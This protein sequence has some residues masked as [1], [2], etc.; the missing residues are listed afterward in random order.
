MSAF[1]VLN[2]RKLF[3]A[4]SGGS[5]FFLVA[6]NIIFAFLPV[7]QYFS[8]ES[9][10]I[11][12]VLITFLSGLSCFKRSEKE[13]NSKPQIRPLLIDFALF[14]L[15]PPI[16]YLITSLFHADC[17]YLSGIKYYL[18][19]TLPAPII[20]SAIAATVKLTGINIQKTIFTI[21]FVVLLFSWV[22]DFYF[23][24]QFYFFNAILTYYPGVIYDEF[25]PVT[26]EIV[27][28]K[29]VIIVVSLLILLVELLT[30]KSDYKKRLYF[31]FG[32]IVV[33]PVLSIFISQEAGIVTP[34]EK[35]TEHFKDG[36][37]TKH[38]LILSEELMTPS[39]RVYYAHL[40]ETYY[41]ELL[42]F[43]EVKPVR[44]LQSVIFSSSA[45]KKKYLGIENA[46]AA[47]PWLGQAYTTRSN[48]EKSLKHE[49][50][51]LFTS[52]FGWSIFKIAGSFNPALIEGAATA[53]DGFIGGYSIDQFAA[54]V[55]ESKYK[56]D[57]SGLF[58]GFNFFSINPSL[59]YLVSGS[60]SKFLI[61]REGIAKFKD[62]YFENDFQAVYNKEQ[63]LF[64]KSYK[65]KLK[66]IKDRPDAKVLDFYFDSKPLVQKSCPRYFAEKM[67]EASGFYGA[68]NYTEALKI[69]DQ[70]AF[71]EGS[72]VPFA[73]KI[74]CLMLLGKDKLA[75]EAIK[76]YE[77]GDL[78]YSRKTNLKLLKYSVLGNS[79]DTITSQVIYNE[80]E[81]SG[82]PEFVITRLRFNKTLI[83]NGLDPFVYSV[84]S[85]T[86]R[87]EM[88]KTIPDYRKKPEVLEAIVDIY[89]ESFSRFDELKELNSYIEFLPASAKL[90]LCLL[91]IKTFKPDEA[92]LILES[93][94]EKELHYAQEISKYR[95]LRAVFAI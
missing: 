67:D 37:I 56:T 53:A 14:I 73:S 38:F 70:F 55:F 81:K 18:L 45:T 89:A 28:Y 22:V 80:L 71:R 15:I 59:A 94:V 93:I 25:I 16:I 50:A 33:L 91:F 43:Y 46:D 66:E 58:S 68:G 20:G 48:I 85:G 42:S 26:G 78:S 64:V 76:D 51:H 32:I 40:H 62:Y 47:K 3:F 49:L 24:P 88:L 92:R 29:S 79:G 87:I 17:S 44:H 10:V 84:Q 6:A 11:N 60:F 4:F 35:L 8:Y 19:F 86:K 52:E 30:K 77:M 82:T 1:P 21:L 72:F 61:E 63:E 23:H 90:R 57:V 41:E 69:Y 27:L 34:K 5:I 75:L 7:I 9:A 12:S 39:E 95:I 36:I 31:G 65:L 54:A 13:D 83:S 74:Y 2:I